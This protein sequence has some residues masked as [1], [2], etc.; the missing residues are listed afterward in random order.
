MLAD[1]KPMTEARDM[2]TM[3]ALTIHQPYAA[4]IVLSDDNAGL[5]ARRAG[6]PKRVENRS[7]YTKRRGHFLVHAGK[8]TASLRRDGDEQLPRGV[9]VGSAE[10]I[11]C[12]HIDAIRRGEFDDV[13]PWLREHSHALGPWCWVIG[14]VRRFK[15]PWPAVGRQGWFTLEVTD[16]GR[17][18]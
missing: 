3:P 2:S 11:D 18:C 15:K 12:I 14:S 9:V 16:V 8:S 10:L 6:G 1:G 5:W 17:P 7:W 4:L 13:Y